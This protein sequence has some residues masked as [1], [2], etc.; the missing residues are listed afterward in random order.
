[1]SLCDSMYIFRMCVCYY[2]C[3]TL[4]L[5]LYYVCYI[6]DSLIEEKKRLLFNDLNY[7]H[8]LRKGKFYFQLLLQLYK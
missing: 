3:Q 5:V 2:I 8:V 6:C 7:Y 4:T 1:M